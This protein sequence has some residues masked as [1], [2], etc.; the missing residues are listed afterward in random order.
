MICAQE[1]INFTSKDEQIKNYSKKK[2]KI[3]ISGSS[4]WISGLTDKS[5]RRYKRHYDSGIF[6]HYK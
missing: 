2:K 3:L 4:G 1:W 5:N 6:S